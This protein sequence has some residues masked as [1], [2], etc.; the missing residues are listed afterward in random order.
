MADWRDRGYVPDS[1]EE[2][3]IESPELLRSVPKASATPRR[4]VSRAVLGDRD[5]SSS[6]DPLSDPTTT[7]T[8]TTRPHLESHESAEHTQRDDFL[9]SVSQILDGAIPPS[10][11]EEREGNVEV[12]VTKSRPSWPID[13]LFSSS[14]TGPDHDDAAVPNGDPPSPQTSSPLS[15]VRSVSTVF[16]PTESPRYKSPTRVETAKHL[17]LGGEIEAEPVQH[18]LEDDVNVNGLS[19]EQLEQMEGVRR[20]KR[21]R[22]PIQ[23][24]PYLLEEQRY[25]QT[26]KSRGLKPVRVAWSQARNSPPRRQSKPSVGDTEY[27]SDVNSGDDETQVPRGPSLAPI[28]GAHTSTSVFD[29]P[30][31]DDTGI[32]FQE[33]ADSD[34]L[35][36]FPREDDDELPDVRSFLQGRSMD[37][38]RHSEERRKINHVYG[39]RNLYLAQNTKKAE[40]NSLNAQPLPSQSRTD[41]PSLQ[42]GLNSPPPSSS[43]IPPQTSSPRPSGFRIPRG[44]SPQTSGF[45]IPR[46]ASPQSLPTPTTSSKPR[47]PQEAEIVP[48]SSS[49]AESDS[50]ADENVNSRGNSRTTTPEAPQN[51]EGRQLQKLQRRIKGVLPASWLRLDQ[52]AQVKASKPSPSKRLGRNREQT[53]GIARKVSHPGHDQPSQPYFAILIPD[54]SD[55]SAGESVGR[56]VNHPEDGDAV[57]DNLSNIAFDTPVNLDDIQE[58]NRVDFM[59]PSLSR[60]N[61]R[62][63]TGINQERLNV[64]S[65]AP[66]GRNI[67]PPHRKSE[68]KSKRQSRITDHIPKQCRHAQSRAAPKLSILDSADVLNRSPKRI[69]PF[70]KIAAR[71]VRSKRDKGRHSPTGKFIRLSTREDTANAMDTLNRWRSGSLAE[72]QDGLISETGNVYS[73]PPLKTR[74]ANNQRRLFQEKFRSLHTIA[75]ANNAQNNPVMALSIARANQTKPTAP[76]VPRPSSLRH[77]HLISSLR[78]ANAPRAAQLEAMSTSQ[79]KRMST[80]QFAK[81]LQSLSIRDTAPETAPRRELNLP[82]ARFLEEHDD[83]AFEPVPFP[84]V[85]SALPETRPQS[86]ESGPRHLRKLTHRPRKRPPVRLDTEVVD[87][88][89]PMQPTIELDDFDG[90]SSTSPLPGDNLVGFNP[91]AAAYTTDFDVT[92]LQPGTYFHESSFIGGEE[93]TRSLNVS[94]RDFDKASGHASFRVLQQSFRWGPWNESVSSDFGTIFQLLTATLEGGQDVQMSGNLRSVVQSVNHQTLLRSVISYVTEHLNFIDRIDRESFALRCVQIIRELSMT[95]ESARHDQPP[96]KGTQITMYALVLVNQARQLLGQLTTAE[97]RSS[98]IRHELETLTNNLSE[99]LISHISSEAALNEIK[100]FSESNK[101]Y[102]IRETGIRDNDICVSATVVAF[103]VLESSALTQG[104]FWTIF[105]SQLAH[106]YK[107]D[108]ESCADVRDLEKLWSGIFIMLP[109]LDMNASG[110][111]DPRSR[112][113]KQCDNWPFVQKLVK[114]VTDIYTAN[115][116]GQPASFNGYFRT[117]L[118]RCFYLLKHW[119]WKRC[120]RILE[121]AFDF[122]AAIGLSKLRNEETRDSPKF[123]DEL[124]NVPNLEVEPSDRSFHLL[125]K[126]IAEGIRTLGDI[127]TNSKIRSIVWRLIPNHGRSYPKEKSIRQE[128]LDA[129]RN[130]H[131]LLCTL[132]WASPA[133]FRPRL[134]TIQNLVHPASSHREACSISIHSWARLLRYQ[135]STDEAAAVLVP[136]AEWHDDFMAQMLEQH[137]AARTEAESARAALN[138]STPFFESTVAQNQRQ[139]EALLADGLLSLS[140][141]FNCVKTLDHAPVLLTSKSIPGALSLLD[142]NN[143]RLNSVISQALDT[144]VSY[145]RIW[146]VP[147]NPNTTAS[148]PDPSED[149]QEFGD[150]SGFD[151]ICPE[152]TANLGVQHLQKVVYDSLA[153]LLSNCFGSDTSPDDPLLLKL[154]DCWTTV[155]R[156]LVKE[157]LKE[158]S[159]YFGSYERESW[160]SLRATDQTRKFTPLFFATVLEKD[161]GCYEDNKSSIQ[162]T[163]LSSIVERDSMLKFQHRLTSALLNVDG[164]NPLLSNLPFS[165]DSR[166][167]KFDVYLEEFSQRRLSLISCLLSNMRSSVQEATWQSR[168]QAQALRQ[169]YREL[170]QHLMSAMKSNYQELGPESSAKGAYVDF[171]HRVVEFLQ[172]HTVEICPIDRFFTDSSAFPLPATDPMYV[173]GRLG[174]YGLRLSEPGVPK[175]LVTFIQNVAERAAADGETVYLVGQLYSALTKLYDPDAGDRLSL[176][177]FVMQNIFPAYIEITFDNPAALAVAEPILDSIQKIFE[178]KFW[179]TNTYD[180]ASLGS[181]KCTLTGVI[182]AARVAGDAFGLQFGGVNPDARV[183][184]RALRKI[185]SMITP[186]IPIIDYLQRTSSTELDLICYI[187]YFQELCRFVDT[188]SSR[189][190]REDF[191]NPVAIPRFE[192][193]SQ[194]IRLFV[195]RELR[196]TI[197]RNWVYADHAF[198][199]RKGGSLW[200]EVGPVLHDLNQEWAALEED[201]K[202]FSEAV[203]AQ[204]IDQDEQETRSA[205]VR[206]RR[207]DIGLDELFL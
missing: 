205:R 133:G 82:L 28:P 35:F 115:P 195:S 74:Q 91:P 57:S 198:H 123:L 148:N 80:L 7:L 137:A 90:S 122:F 94:R 46:G 189:L 79:H 99:Q 196:T 107:V 41:Q 2:D 129:L 67:Q 22:D 164:Q 203:K 193:P 139:I 163:W 26:V 102:Q 119:G 45:H 153:R 76:R 66:V 104:T 141:A 105:S 95:I 43:P 6:P 162:G 4:D 58:D 53:K 169:E 117:I 51:K 188:N 121:T 207:K 152:K 134:A 75:R 194:D 29:I 18:G 187:R 125:L 128:D 36:D 168:I 154:T 54:D 77:G 60:P 39:K 126:I 78:S 201:M 130:Q 23:L 97:I 170:L 106:S 15:S 136:F 144:L 31:D 47:K 96:A 56:D 173:V 30:S 103:H 83:T 150:W 131:D 181:I 161:A 157:G 59:L 101:R 1:D 127:Y 40:K 69:P 86:R 202:A 19:M 138:I 9:P 34:A 33:Q 176:S 71:R 149:S 172:Q 151:E 64:S 199:V 25:Q 49:R 10:R 204:G 38:T 108:V 183:Y 114:T 44:A 32:S 98:T 178:D 65:S 191:I 190:V 68:L 17:V 156:A 124:G 116:N 179:F 50:E 13:Q 140:K 16:S 147:E 155:A 143:H 200:N 24:H 167:G 175:Q 93:F 112:N 109:L 37:P 14:Q 184:L 146:Q 52:Q 120:E 182:E 87:I 42:D 8:R 174:N 85:E 12:V 20:S 62:R 73:R 142:P 27:E 206:A 81:S 89:Q 88:R 100:A 110:I 55:D 118:S 166:S 160:T 3:S 111:L 197:R 171:V 165:V 11:E 159:D 92:P 61:K 84:S 70:L 177:A 186:T 63:R 158:W 21:H 48:V 192:P 132:Y 135:L 72:G 5:P 113:V 185:I 145:I 180:S